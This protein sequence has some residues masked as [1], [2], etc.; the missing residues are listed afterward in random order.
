M[1]EGLR[2]GC[3][4]ILTQTGQENLSTLKHGRDCLVFESNN[5]RSVADAIVSVF[6][7]KD[8]LRSMSAAARSTYQQEFS[9]VDR[10]GSEYARL[11]QHALANPVQRDLRWSARAQVKP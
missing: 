6:Q 2:A 8:N 10:M 11:L 3:I 4:P 1:I 9:D 7:N 5:L